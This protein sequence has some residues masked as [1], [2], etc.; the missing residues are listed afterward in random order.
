MEVRE[1]PASARPREKLVAN[2]PEYLTDTELLSV[3]LGSG[4]KG[5][6]VLRLAGAVLAHLDAKDYA[7]R[8]ADLVTIPGLGHAKSALIVA[9]LEFSRRVLCPEKKR[10]RVPSD[11]LPFVRHYCDREQEFFLAVSLN[12]AHEVKAVR[13]VSIGLVN[14]TLIHPREVFAGAIGDRAAAII[15]AHNHPSGN[16][17]PSPEDRETTERLREV[18]ALLGITLLD[19]IIFTDTAY[20][21]FQ[22]NGGF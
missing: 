1:M 7:A 3:L 22:E 13:V 16:T 9:A 18:G 6:G 17:D 19:H 10:I 4:T 5:N 12:G 8:V 15:C 21:S 20:Y 14:R 11:L 2:G